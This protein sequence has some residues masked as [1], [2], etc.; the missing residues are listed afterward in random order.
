M[1]ASQDT[2]VLNKLYIPIHIVSWKRAVSLLYQDLAYS[3]D[4]ELIAYSYKDWL[5]YTNNPGFDETYYNMVHS[6]T[7]TMA[8]PDILLLSNNTNKQT[9]QI[10]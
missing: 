7:I 3:L 5:E 8:V 6:T 10:N 2:L 9:K 1:A 4:Q